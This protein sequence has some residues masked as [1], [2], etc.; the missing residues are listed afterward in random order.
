MTDKKSLGT[1]RPHLAQIRCSLSAVRR[2]AVQYAFGTWKNSETRS[3][4]VHV[5]AHAH[6]LVS[7]TPRSL[8]QGSLS[9]ANRV[10]GGGGQGDGQAHWCSLQPLDHCATAGV[11]LVPWKGP[12]CFYHTASP[13]QRLQRCLPG[14]WPV[15]GPL[16][17]RAQCRGARCGR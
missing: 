13:L 16:S 9:S 5:H 4:H 3:H 11:S 8:L 7:T 15:T 12:R 1:V 10:F 2:G 14:H 6:V 17:P